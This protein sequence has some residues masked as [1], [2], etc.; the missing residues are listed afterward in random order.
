M[1]DQDPRPA[2]G[3]EAELFEAYSHEL[4]RSVAGAVVR[5]T[6]QVIEDACAFAWAQFM[7]HQPDR[8]RNWRGWGASSAPPALW[9]DVELPELV[10]VEYRGELVALV[11]RERVHLISPR[12]RT[13]AAGDPELRFV[14]YICLYIGEVLNGRLP[15][16][17]TGEL[18]E[19]WARAALISARELASLS[20]CSDAEAAEA[21]N[22]PLDQVSAARCA[23]T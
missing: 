9:N 8:D 7:E 11:S 15:G 16:P 12:M 1:A 21:L 17:I 5:T 20:A 4:I 6:P 10:P 19:Q 13:R 3:D 2:R 23:A 18:A 14:G 22:V